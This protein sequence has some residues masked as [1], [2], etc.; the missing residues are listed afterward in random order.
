MGILLS[1]VEKAERRLA[2]FRAELETARDRI[3]PDL[4]ADDRFAI[5]EDIKTLEG[6]EAAALEALSGARELAAKAEADAAKEDA[7]N[8]IEAYRREAEREAP[9]RLRKFDKLARS[10]AAELNW[11]ADHRKRADDV[12]KLAREFG[13][14]GALLHNVGMP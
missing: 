8:L 7:R 5:N 12:N 1:P 4:D 14:R 13:L 2:E 9:T 6:K 11:L 3:R 10:A